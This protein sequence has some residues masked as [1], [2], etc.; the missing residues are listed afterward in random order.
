MPSMDLDFGWCGGS[1][2]S[3]SYGNWRRNEL[4]S[5][6]SIRRILRSGEESLPELDDNGTRNIF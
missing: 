1:P 5:G 6:E 2:I 3:L 4:Q